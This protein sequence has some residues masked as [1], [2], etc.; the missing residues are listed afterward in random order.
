MKALNK[1]KLMIA[2][3]LLGG[4]MFSVYAEHLTIMHTNDTHSQIDP[5]FS[6][7]G[8]I[9]RRKVIIDSIRNADKN[10]LLVDAGDAV[11]GTM[12][13]VLFGGEVDMAMMDKLGYDIQILGNHEFDNGIDSLAFFY[14][15]T[16]PLKLSTNYDFT[17]T[18]LEGY[19]Q[20]YIIKEYGGKKVAF[21]GINLNPEGLIIPAAIKGVKYKDQ[22]KTA[23]ETASM[24]K[25]EKGVDL[26]VMLSHIGYG[27]EKETIDTDPEI[28]ASSHDIDIVIGGHSHTT[29]DPENPKSVKYLIE[30]ADG[31]N[32]LVTQTGK[33]GQNLGVIDIDLDDMEASYKLIPVTKRYDDRIDTVLQNWLKPYTAKVDSIMN[34]TIVYSEKEMPSGKTGALT[35]WVADLAKRTGDTL[36]GQP[37]DMAIMNKGGIRRM[38]PKGEISEGVL[39]S[40]FPF[41]NHLVILKIKGD[42]LLEGLEVMAKR[43]G[44]AVS[45]ELSVRY[46][47]DNKITSAKFN[48][49]SIK[50]DK[51]YT[52]ATLDYLAGGGDYMESFKDGEVLIV[53][54]HVFSTDVL[55]YA[56]YLGDK[57]LMI[58][59][60]DESRMYRE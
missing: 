34:H 56:R 19:F 44:D 29:I 9:L 10:T 6:D 39:M 11:T 38:M 31:R 14:K 26:V 45:K 28:I 35:N 27:K 43:G 40:M 4:I 5:D 23:N 41:S 15:K 20:P 53:S 58:K 36:Y 47:K 60:T 22:L 17:G 8:G 2:I 51:Y 55:D 24:L 7:K 57:G 50:K 3:V 33:A 46:N 48:G 49:K 42:D 13:S 37:I 30:N 18:P 32:V 25:K 16:K 54:P 12:Y 52:I 1:K 21:I 59:S